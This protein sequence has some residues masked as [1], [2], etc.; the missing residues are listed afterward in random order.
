MERGSQKERD[1]LELDRP[2]KPCPFCGGVAY[3][4]RT[5][6]GTDMVCVGC[7]LCGI[8][9]KAAIDFHNGRN[10]LTR[11]VLS[12]WNRRGWCYHA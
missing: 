10:C 3:V 8:E 9:M 7:S 6:N 2:L 11:D 5:C 1:E 12:M 4:A